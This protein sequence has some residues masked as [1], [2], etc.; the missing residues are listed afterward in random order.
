[1]SE[2]EKVIQFLV[3]P[4]EDFVGRLSNGAL[5]S[6]RLHVGAFATQR[7]R[8]PLDLRLQALH[9]TVSLWEAQAG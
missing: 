4:Q 2:I 5:P 7:L 1:M 6:N 9:G 3:C 8:G